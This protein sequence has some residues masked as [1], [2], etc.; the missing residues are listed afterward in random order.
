[1]DDIKR[2]VYLV[3]R[4][5]IKPGASAEILFAHQGACHSELEARTGRTG[6][7]H[8]EPFLV[9]LANRLGAQHL[10]EAKYRA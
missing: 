3:P 10:L 4:D 6:W 9:Q 5:A 2:A 7:H 1:M 8:L